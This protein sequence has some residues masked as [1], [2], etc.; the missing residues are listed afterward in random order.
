VTGALGHIGS[1]LIHDLP[2]WSAAPSVLVDNMA[3]QRYPA[4]FNLPSG[5][6]YLFHEADAMGS[7]LPE[8]LEA[9]DVVVHLAA[10]T[11]AAGSFERA[12][13]VERVNYEGT[14]IL[15]EACARAGKR[16]V[17]L[18]TTS[19]Y[20]T[21]SR[22]VDEG[23]GLDELKPQSPYADSKLRAEQYLARLVHTQGL[24]CVILRFGT[25][26]GV[27]PG[28]RFHTAVNKFIWQAVNGLPLTVWRSALDQR[29]PYLDLEDAVRALHHV[30]ERDLFDGTV[31][32]V[33]TCN[34][35]VREII[36]AIEREVSPVRV[37]LV[38]SQIMNQLSY[39]VATARFCATGFR[40]TGSLD[41]GV[42]DTVKLLAGIRRG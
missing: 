37:E 13:E 18:S 27:S 5:G 31:Y 9:T 20:G 14:R 34:L 15:A 28:M 39:E 6:R 11:D 12:A 23:C 33:L 36:S 32:N 22:I 1:R 8:F 40:F 42:R 16:L 24:L 19:V 21:Q 17:F 38:D 4:L 30:V 3:T 26:F 41:R 10:I 25:I 29:R 2:A 7:R 35:T